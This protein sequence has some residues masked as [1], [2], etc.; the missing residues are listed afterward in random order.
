MTSKDRTAAAGTT[1]GR[2]LAG[3]GLAVLLLG[4]GAIVLSSDA[5]EEPAPVGS[6]TA[7]PSATTPAAPQPKPKNVRIPVRGIGAYD[8]DGDRSE[9]DSEAPLA[10][11]GILTTAWK[12]ERYR[13]SFSKSGV[14]LVVD[15]GRPMMARQ[16][17]VATE[18]PGYAADV[19]VG[20]SPT[21]PFAPVSKVQS[22]TAR[23]TFVVKPRSARY[24]VLWVTS[25]PEGGAAAVNEITVSG[26]R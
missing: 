14:G 1:R 16:V 2:V 5:D 21:G 10:T 19:R 15:A 13:S 18:T 4:F 6:G 3:T 8:P 22:I 9:N 26:A 23:T 25:V 20:T 12:S 24:L 11:D 7:T 17:V